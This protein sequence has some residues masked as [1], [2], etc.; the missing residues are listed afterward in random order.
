MGI[1]F[2]WREEKNIHE[3]CL[4]PMLAYGGGG[5]R[6]SQVAAIALNIFS[7]VISIDVFEY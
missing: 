3:E 5:R 2:K 6:R 1:V 7:T 4:S